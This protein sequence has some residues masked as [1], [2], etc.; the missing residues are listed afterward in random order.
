MFPTRHLTCQHDIYRCHHWHFAKRLCNHPVEQ[1]ICD[2]TER[3]PE[4]MRHEAFYYAFSTRRIINCFIETVFSGSTCL[5]K[6]FHIGKHC[7]RIVRA[8]HNR[9]VRCNHTVIFPHAFYGKFFQSECLIFIAHIDVQYVIAG[10]RNAPGLSARL[11][12]FNLEH[13]LDR[14][15]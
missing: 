14:S 2:R 8:C 7:F 1:Q 5:Y 15:A 6:F 3:H 11:R 10:F 4:M 9:S 13:I 12:H